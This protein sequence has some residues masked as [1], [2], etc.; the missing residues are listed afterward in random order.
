MID[1]LQERIVRTF[2]DAREILVRF[3]ENLKAHELMQNAPYVI[4]DHPAIVKAREDQ[5]AMTAHARDPQ[6][7]AE[8]YGANP[9]ER[10]FEEQY[11][12]QPEDAHLHLYRLQFLREGLQAAALDKQEWDGSGPEHLRILDMAGNDGAFAQN[13]RALGFETDVLDM[14][15]DCVKRAKERPGV[16]SARVANIL[17]PGCTYEFDAVVAFEVLEHLPNPDDLAKSMRRC[18]IPGGLLFIST[19]DGAVEKGN[20]PNWDHVEYKGHLRSWPAAQFRDWL[21]K[22]GTVEAFEVGPDGVAVGKVRV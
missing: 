20:L 11:G 17:D 21:E 7:Y 16:R 3:D 6:V 1:Y 5:A 2:L 10:P 13:L 12:I 22:W 9:H 19:P 15:P 4:W 14:N 8:Y 18:A